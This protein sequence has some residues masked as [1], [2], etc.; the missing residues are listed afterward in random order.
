MGVIGRLLH[1]L[2]HWFHAARRVLWFFTN[3]N[4]TGVHAVALTPTGKIVLVTL[5][6]APG[7]RL[8]GGGR[9]PGEDPEAS[10]KRELR[11]EIGMIACGELQKVMDFTQRADFKND[12]SSLFVVRE[13]VY[14]PRWSLEIKAV[15]EFGLEALPPDMPPITARLIAAAASQL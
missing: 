1:R 12:R 11:E 13:V 2:V 4:S 14:Q 5:S 3:P 7:W 15:E 6:Y 9:K 8:P 10:I